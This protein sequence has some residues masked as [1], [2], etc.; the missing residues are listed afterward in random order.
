M[1][2]HFVLLSLI[3]IAC[4][5][6]NYSPLSFNTMNDSGISRS[7][8]LSNNIF[9]LTHRWVAC[10]CRASVHL[11]AC[12][13][14]WRRWDSK[15]ILREWSLK[16]TF[17]LVLLRMIMLSSTVIQCQAWVHHTSSS[18]VHQFHTFLIL[19][20]TASAN[21]VIPSSFYLERFVSWILLVVLLLTTFDCY[22]CII[23]GT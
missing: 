18:F 16:R 11:C 12:A 13:R 4:K 7:F 10:Q 21:D 5:I 17:I 8:R 20:F 19:L 3:F 6:F 9:M 15:K 22:G 23:K 14:V 1:N 2:F